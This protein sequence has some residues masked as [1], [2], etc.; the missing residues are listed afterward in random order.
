MLSLKVCNSV[1]VGKTL[2]H[3][4][5]D[6]KITIYTKC[7]C[8][9]ESP[10]GCGASTPRNKLS[11]ELDPHLRGCTIV[12]NGK[13]QSKCMTF[14]HNVLHLG[15]NFVCCHGNKLLD[16]LNTAPCK[17]PSQSS[18]RSVVV[19]MLTHWLLTK[20][21]HCF[22]LDAITGLVIIFVGLSSLILPP[23]PYEKKIKITLF[24]YCFPDEV[25]M[26]TD[27]VGPC[28]LNLVLCQVYETLIVTIYDHLLLF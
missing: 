6:R 20:S 24:R 21:K 25:V 3:I 16:I 28:M 17:V 13:G 19:L 5:L 9:E 1:K 14:L 18:W 26:N 12:V 11:T 2:D 10:A 22:N 8:N 27:M 7:P 15:L 4:T 23:F